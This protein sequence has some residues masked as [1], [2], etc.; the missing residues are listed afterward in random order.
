[1]NK[2]FETIQWDWKYLKGVPKNVFGV[3][4]KWERFYEQY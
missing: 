4:Q 3:L 2:I 1:M